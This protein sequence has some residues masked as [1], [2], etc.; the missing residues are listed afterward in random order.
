[1]CLIFVSQD[2]QSWAITNERL[3]RAKANNPHGC[4]L[5]FWDRLKWKTVLNP[6]TEQIQA[7]ARVA[8]CIV[9]YRFATHGE[10][11]ASNTQP[12][13][14]SDNHVFAHNGIVS[15]TLSGRQN[16]DSDSKRIARILQQVNKDCWGEILSMLATGHASRFVLGASG[17]KARLFGAG[18]GKDDTSP[19]VM[20]SD[21]GKAWTHIKY[22]PRD[23]DPDVPA[24]LDVEAY[25]GFCEACG[26]KKTVKWNEEFG[27]D[28]CKDCVA[29]YSRAGA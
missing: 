25:H 24:G 15:G 5:A 21:G 3:D 27:L 26:K 2:P 9:H 22:D 6:S 23:H 12:F 28:L 10:H 18:W 29:F 14:L 17:G 16:T 4:G 11:S 13:R 7:I 19:T 1:M 20:C 8:P